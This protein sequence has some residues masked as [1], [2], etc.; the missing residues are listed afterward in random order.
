MPTRRQLLTSFA[1]GAAL[2][3]AMRV[4]WAFAAA[5]TDKRFVLVILRGALD[6]LHAVPPYAEPEYARLRPALAIPKP[7]SAEG[8][9][10]LD[11]HFGLHPSL[12]PLAE[13][14][15][16]KEL[17]IVPAATTAYRQRSHFDGQDVLENGTPKPFAA[18]DGWL[19][20]SIVELGGRQRL[21]VAVGSGIPVVLRGKARVQNWAPTKLPAADQ[22]F[23]RRLSYV[24][25]ED[26][27]FAN[28]FQL[29]SAPMDPDLDGRGQRARLRFSEAAAAGAKLL[30]AADGPRI[31]VLEA[32]GWDTH[33]NQVGRLKPLLAELA[34]GLVSLKSGL[35][36]IWRDTAVVVVSEFGRTA[37]QNGNNG[38]DHGTGGIAFAL[39]GAL[40]GGRIMGHWPTL[41]RGALLDGRDVRPD[42]D[43]RSIWKGL[44]HDHLGLS[45]G[46]LE[47]R[48]FPESRAARPMD[49]LLRV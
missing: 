12:S 49:G 16:A 43:Y 42:N 2:A 33:I 45:E 44:L 39:G 10:D 3:A 34:E 20:R 30:L 40:A 15:R 17:I 11:G 36:P 4:R 25:A 47:D 23:L 27:T 8:A 9:I 22:D 37:A 5:P 21:G 31:C 19:N 26:P 24:Y 48:V 29:A 7:G 14:Y 46:A 32:E 13:L 1:A 41:E 38:T 35:G 18:S 6:G 28:A